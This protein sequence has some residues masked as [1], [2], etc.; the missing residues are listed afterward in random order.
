M[1][2]NS[3]IRVLLAD[4]HTAVREGI[5]SHLVAQKGME[6]VGEACGG[7]EA[8][9]KTREL[10]P[11]ILILD[12]AMPRVNGLDVAKQLRRQAPD[13]RIIGLS[14][15]D[16][17]EYVVGMVRSGAMGYMS[18]SDP[19]S[20]LVKAIRAVYK[21][22]TFFTHAAAQV[23]LDDYVKHAETIGEASELSKREKEILAQIVDGLTNKEIGERFSISRRTVE[24]HRLHIRKKLGVE[25]TADLIKYAVVNG[26]VPDESWSYV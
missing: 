18:K 11:D 5:R 7:E 13:T 20:T 8:I 10:R 24:T 21:G 6:V 16:N 26:I 22:E 15:Y 4:D 12:V 9:R 1:S 19:P 23:L 14:V 25:T 17:N 3:T 2:G